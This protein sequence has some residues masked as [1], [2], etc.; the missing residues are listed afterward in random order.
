MIVFSILEEK[1]KS[2]HLEFLK[3]P[4]KNVKKKKCKKRP[5]IANM[6]VRELT[7]IKMKIL[8]HSKPQQTLYI[9]D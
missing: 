5:L 3:I 2:V 7:V 9:T 6:H 8:Q 4:F 1:K